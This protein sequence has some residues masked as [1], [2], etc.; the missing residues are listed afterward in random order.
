M[1]FH[2]Y[3]LIIRK[4]LDELFSQCALVAVELI[5]FLENL[6]LKSRESKLAGLQRVLKA[7]GIIAKIQSFEGQINAYQSQLTLRLLAYMNAKFDASS[8]HHDVKLTQLHDDQ[9]KVMEVLALAQERIIN[10]SVDNSDRV[11]AAVL[12]LTDGGTMTII[13]GKSSTIDPRGQSLN[14]LHRLTLRSDPSETQQVAFLTDFGA[15]ITWPVLGRL[16]FRHIR[17]RCDTVKE[18]HGRTLEWLFEASDVDLPWSHFP[19]WLKSDGICYWINGKPGSGKTTLMKFISQDYRT[20]PLALSWANQVRDDLP[21]SRNRVL[22]ASFFFW[23]LG[24]FS[25]QKS[26]SG[27]LR[28]LLHDIL[29]QEPTLI[30]TVVPELCFDVIGSRPLG[31]IGE[32]TLPE[33]QRWFK[34]LLRA[35][36]P[37][38]RFCFIIDGVDEYTGNLEELIGVLLGQPNHFVKFIVSSRPTI[39][40]TDAFSKYPNLRLQDLTQ[41]DIRDYAKDAFNKRSNNAELEDLSAVIEDVTERSSGVFLW[42]VL[43][44]RSLLKGIENGDNT[45]ELLARLREL[46][47]DLAELYGQ[48]LSA[49]P[50]NYRSQAANLFRIMVQS[51]EYEV[52]RGRPYPVSTLRMSFAEEPHDAAISARIE[53]MSASEVL[54]RC[55]SIDRRIRSRCCGLLEVNSRLATSIDSA[56]GRELHPPKRIPYVEF[57]HRSVVEFFTD[58]QQL[59]RLSHGDTYVVNEPRASLFCSHIHILKRCFASTSLNHASFTPSAD[60]NVFLPIAMVV[61]M[62]ALVDALD[63]ENLGYPLQPELLNE[64]DRAMSYHWYSKPPATSSGPQGHWV[65]MLIYAVIPSEWGISVGAVGSSFDALGFQGIALL[66]PLPSY[67]GAWL[68]AQSFSTRSASEICTELLHAWALTKFKLAINPSKKGERAKI[69]GH[70]IWKMSRHTLLLPP[71]TASNT[72]LVQLLLEAG[73]DPNRR[74]GE[75][76]SA[77]HIFLSLTMMYLVYEDASATQVLR[78][79]ELFVSHG[80]TAYQVFPSNRLLE[81]PEFSSGCVLSDLSRAGDA[82][83]WNNLRLVKFVEDY[84]KG[85]AKGGEKVVILEGMQSILLANTP[86]N[87]HDQTE[88]PTSSVE[89]RCWLRNL[90]NRCYGTRKGN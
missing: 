15:T 61:L 34:R 64:L 21:Q 5:G 74:I 85:L 82:G 45:A 87:G 73:A 47:T 56:L 52:C 24:P 33:L 19:R 63:A 42:V 43:V 55:A 22:L 11:L 65:R 60:D 44:T 70:S 40:C 2:K 71:W 62:V 1:R 54:K 81:N 29:E 80:V 7:K 38:M 59:E 72:R 50:P 79:L 37:T 10:V 39:P 69:R 20:E 32:P 51:I 30:P 8:F 26:Q 3:L 67:I 88:T 4:A 28:A 25:L 48:I 13:K 49:I 76:P 23:N 18:R 78:L 36:C 31:E 14:K 12:K 84:Y 68:E 57:I 35:A 58:T 41:E 46:P 75:Y 9:S 66:L 90:V 6:R 53:A 27:L 86:D 89:G 77:F 83:D 17:D 16:K